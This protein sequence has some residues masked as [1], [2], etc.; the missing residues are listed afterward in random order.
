MRTWRATACSSKSQ[1]GDSWAVVCW[2]RM[3]QERRQTAV[4]RA[5]VPRVIRSGHH[6]DHL[7]WRLHCHRQCQLILPRQKWATLGE[8]RRSRSHPMAQPRRRSPPRSG[9]TLQQVL[10]WH[11]PEACLP[12]SLSLTHALVMRPS[13]PWRR[14]SSRSFAERPK[15]AR[16]EKIGRRGIAAVRLRSMGGTM[17]GKN[18]NSWRGTS[19]NLSINKKSVFF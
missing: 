16:R 6:H 19:N 1:V 4:S 2:H 10:C 15:M 18:T 11:S 9:T 13:K 12:T 5:A 3:P 8:R 7:R 14:S 17:D